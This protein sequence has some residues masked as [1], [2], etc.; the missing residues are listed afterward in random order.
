MRYAEQ[1]F[2]LRS[3]EEMKARFAEVPEAVQNTLE[4]AEKCNLEIEFGKLHYPVF[5]PPE[6]FTREGYLRQ[7]LAEGLQRRYSIHAR[8]EGKEFI[9]EGIEDPRRLPTYQAVQSPEFRVQSPERRRHATSNPGPRTLNDPAVAAAVKAVLDR[10]QLE[11]EVIEKTGFIS[12]FLIV[13]D[14]VRYGR[15]HGRCLR[16]ARFGGRFARHLPAGNLERRSDPLRAAV[17]ALPQSRTRQ[18][19]GY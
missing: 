12:Y 14:F 3:A 11:L 16:G 4:V 15:E 8:A 10:L 17:R 5:H 13:G 9:V 6:H 1:Q 2:Y 19:A 7:L 18:P